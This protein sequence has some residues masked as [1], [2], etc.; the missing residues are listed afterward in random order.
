MYSTHN[1]GNSVIAEIFIRTLKNKI[2]KYVTSVSKKM[3][4]DQLDDTVNKYSNTCH[5]TIKMK[6][7]DVKSSTY[8][9]SNKEINVK[10]SKFKVGVLLEYQNIKLVLQKSML[11]L[12]L[13]TKKLLKHFTKKNY[14]KQIKKS[15]ELKK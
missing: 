10:Y 1:E 3:H 8:T 7:V 13:K 12:V 9:D 15:L 4:A 14:K 6:L 2:Y 11:L 5:N